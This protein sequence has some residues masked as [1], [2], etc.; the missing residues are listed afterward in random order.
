MPVETEESRSLEE[1]VVPL[2]FQMFR[3]PSILRQEQG[4]RGIK[5]SQSDDATMGHAPLA[6]FYSASLAWPCRLFP[7]VNRPFQPCVRPSTAQAA[8][9]E[10]NGYGRTF[11]ANIPTQ[12]CHGPW[13]PTEEV[14]ITLAPDHLENEGSLSVA[15]PELVLSKL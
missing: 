9:K 8:V 12:H 14:Y 4:K 10:L 2:P 6:F 5:G 11:V 1:A 15:T 7:K 3:H 13:F